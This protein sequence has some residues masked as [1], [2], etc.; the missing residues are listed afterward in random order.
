MHSSFISSAVPGGITRP[1]QMST[2]DLE[3]DRLGLGQVDF[4][5]IDTEG[6]D[7][8]VLVGAAS[9]LQRGDIGV[10][11]F[12][13]NK[14]WR[15]AGSTLAAAYQ[16]LEKHG[17]SVYLLRKDGLYSLR[18]ALYGEYF[19]YSNFVALRPDWDERLK[20]FQ[21]GPI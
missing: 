7:L 12:E 16:L 15:E 19:E 18:Y 9:R 2:I 3:L 8:R 6:Y 10:V 17:Y 13:Y 4:L 1:V 11:Q 5:K 14:P 20:R 21:R